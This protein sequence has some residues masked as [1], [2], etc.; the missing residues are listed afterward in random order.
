MIQQTHTFSQWLTKLKDIRA[1]ITIARRLERAETG[2]LGDISITRCA[3][4]N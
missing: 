4:M 3:E 1:R 2:N